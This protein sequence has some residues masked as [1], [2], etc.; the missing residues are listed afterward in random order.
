MNPKQKQILWVDNQHDYTGAHITR[1]QAAGHIVSKAWSAEEA[2]RFLRDPVSKCDLIILDILMSEKPV[3]GQKVGSGKT[4]LVLYDI[5]RDDLGF[6]GPILVVTVVVDGS[7]DK[8]MQGKETPRGLPVKVLHKPVRP[9][10]LNEAIQAVLP[11][12]DDEE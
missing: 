5:I 8:A 10:E 9:S 6:R 2:L 3:E 12:G 4:G 1:L 11:P 7:V